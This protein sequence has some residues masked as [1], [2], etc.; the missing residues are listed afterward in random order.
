MPHR[1][2]PKCGERTFVYCD[3]GNYR[4]GYHCSVC[5]YE[6]QKKPKLP[7]TKRRKGNQMGW[8][9]KTPEKV[10]FDKE[11]MELIGR[12]VSITPT[13][14]KVNSYKLV[15]EEGR[16]KSFLGTTVL[17]GVLSNELGSLVKIVYMGSSKTGSGFQ[18]KNFRVFVDRDA[19]EEPIEPEDKPSKNK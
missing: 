2:C 7:K 4:I 14:L 12:I 13:E 6:V 19:S 11:G 1:K 16:I 15:E 9:E 3:L 8:E 5:G 17:D 18:V 10:T